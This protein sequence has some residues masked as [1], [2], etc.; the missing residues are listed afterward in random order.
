MRPLETPTVARP[1]TMPTLLSKPV[2]PTRGAVLFLKKQKPNES[3]WQFL[4]TTESF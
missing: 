2:P 1:L 3:G 4:V